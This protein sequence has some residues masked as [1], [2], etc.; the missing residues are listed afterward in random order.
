MTVDVFA[1]QNPPPTTFPFHL[2]HLS[3]LD[4]PDQPILS[5]ILQPTITSL[6]FHPTYVRQTHIPTLTSIGHQIKVLRIGFDI[7]S[8]LSKFRPFLHACVALVHL[9]V[10]TTDNYLTVMAWI[11]IP[12]RT[13]AIAQRQPTKASLTQLHER[14]RSSTAGDSLSALW[15]LRFNAGEPFITRVQAGN[16]LLLECEVRGIVVEFGA[17]WD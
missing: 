2:T 11:P 16:D 15:R 1:D 6:N 13:L 17:W 10:H 9:T 8:G 14:L 4:V 7:E 5:T 3:L 12:I